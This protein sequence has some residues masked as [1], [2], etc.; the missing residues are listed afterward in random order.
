MGGLPVGS[1][2]ITAFQF[3]GY[4]IP[5]ALV[6]SLAVVLV[7]ML[8]VCITLKL[9]DSLMP[10]DKSLKFLAPVAIL[11][12]IGMAVHSIFFTSS[13]TTDVSGV[14]ISLGGAFLTGLVL[15]I[16]N[17]L[18]YPF[19]MVWNNI[20]FSNPQ[21]KK[22]LTFL[23]YVVGIGCGTLVSLACFVLLGAYSIRKWGVLM[24][25]IPLITG[26]VYAL[27]AAWFTYRYFR[28]LRID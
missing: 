2:N 21:S 4:A 8:V 18:Q 26:S 27:T 22:N 5:P 10:L 11:A 24:M 12:L 23:V 16:S 14:A 20:F 3:A 7:E 25:Y 1:L 28:S 15:S 13:D 19:W 17:P 6:F 9:N